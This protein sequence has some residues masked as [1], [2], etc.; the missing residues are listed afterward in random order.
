MNAQARA[1]TLALLL[2]GCGSKSTPALDAADPCV[3]G[4]TAAELMPCVEESRLAT[5]IEEV[6]KE[7]V[8]G[9]AHWQTVQDLCRTRLESYGYQVELESYATGTNVIGRME[10]ADASAGEVIVSAHY[11][12]IA[13]CPGASDNAAGVA[14]ALELARVLAGRRFS[15]SL[16]IA[17]WDEEE[18]GLIG[19]RV[20]ADAA[21]ASSQTIKA[22]I[23]FD[24]IGFFASE[25]DS[26]TLPAG[27]EALFPSEYAQVQSNEFRG[28]FVS[29]IADESS[30][31][32]SERF[33]AH[34][35]SLGLSVIPLVVP[36]SL[37]LSAAIGDL[38]R[39]DHASFWA[40][41]YPGLHINDTANFRNPNYH[42][43]DGVDT[44]DT[45]TMG[46]VTQITQ[47]AL[48]ASIDTLGAI[49][50]G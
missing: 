6:A 35:M 23:S 38:R 22:T 44:P 40:N 14:A 46:V 30:R 32:I 45:L 18:R 10:G 49:T 34:G 19:S 36:E 9:S 31:E 8:P 4:T 42:C 27:F 16:V 11:D 24:A 13:N 26:Q 28:D 7:R 33:V 1:L 41:D 21:K 17:C 50:G 15:S 5:D 47:A 12:H 20:Y 25:P 29:L 43:F 2:S 37:K 39:S 48:G 3:V